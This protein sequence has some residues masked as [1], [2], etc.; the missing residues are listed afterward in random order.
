MAST[1]TVTLSKA[2]DGRLNI[3]NN[4]T[5]NSIRPVA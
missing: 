4:L 2:E 3:D 5:E 1:E